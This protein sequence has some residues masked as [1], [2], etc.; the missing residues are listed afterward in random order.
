[1]SVNNNKF[2]VDEYF[3]PPVSDSSRLIVGCS[4][5]DYSASRIARAVEDCDAHLLNLNVTSPGMR[6]PSEADLDLS[7]E[8]GESRFPIVCDIRVSHRDAAAITRSL[9]RYGYTVIDW[10]SDNVADSDTSRQRIEHLF[11]YL[12]I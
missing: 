4:R 10:Q 9:E 2:P 3:Y 6:Y 8:G 11:R 12:E 5:A 7:P 1:M